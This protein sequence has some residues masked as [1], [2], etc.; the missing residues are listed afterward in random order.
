[1]TSLAVN[2]TNF[3]WTEISTVYEVLAAALV[4]EVGMALLPD[5]WRGRMHLDDSTSVGDTASGA[6]R[7]VIAAA[8]AIAATIAVLVALRSLH[9]T[10]KLRADTHALARS[11]EDITG[12][13]RSGDVT[14]GWTWHETVW[15]A[16]TPRDQRWSPEQ[17][18]QEHMVR[19]LEAQ[20]A[21]ARIDEEARR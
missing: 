19:V 21:Q 13:L 15:T 20:R 7:F 14:T 17:L 2:A 5:R 11:V 18:V 6:F 1:M 16:R 12:M 4:F 3:D 10:Q 8:M 9:E